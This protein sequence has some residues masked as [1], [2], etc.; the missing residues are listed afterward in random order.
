MLRVQMTKPV[1]ARDE[2]GY[3]YTYEIRGQHPR[4]PCNPVVSSL[5][6]LADPKTPDHVHL[7]VGRAVNLV[8][9]IDEWGKQC[10]SKEVVLRGYWPGSDSSGPMVKGMVSA[11]KKGKHCHRLER[12]FFCCMLSGFHNLKS[13]L[14]PRSSRVGRFVHELALYS[15]GYLGE[16]QHRKSLNTASVESRNTEENTE[17]VIKYGH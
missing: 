16:G 11:G 7:K 9:R 6:N 2:P 1:S 12:T 13:K 5:S 15:D 17:K 14:R 10:G 8:K 4:I 3:I